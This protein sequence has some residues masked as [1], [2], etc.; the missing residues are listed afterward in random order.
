M[1]PTLRRLRSM[2][3]ASL[4]VLGAG[5]LCT[6][7][8][9]ADSTVAAIV[10]FLAVLLVSGYSRMLEAVIADII[11]AFWLDYYHIPP[12]GSITIGD[13]QGWFALLVFLAVSLI[14]T[15][16]SARLRRQRDQLILQQTE[17]EKLHA[18]SRT[19][20][21]ASGAEDGRRLLINKCMELFGFNEVVLFESA[22]SQF[23]R[24]QIH[25]EIPDEKLQ[26]AAL[27]RSVE[28][29]ADLTIIPVELGNKSFGSLAFRGA[30]LARPMLQA[31][32]N[33][34][35]VGLAQAQA[36]E[37][38]GR[39]EAVRRSEEL[40]SVLI[41]ALAHDLKTP[42]TA[43]EAA[44]DILL[45]PSGASASQRYDLLQV[46]REETLRLKRLVGE[47]IHLS[48][49]DAKKLKLEY[50]TVRVPELIDGAVESLGGRLSTHQISIEVPPDLPAVF[51][52]R[53]LILQSLK[54]LLD[55]AIKYSPP[56]S[57]VTI[58]AGEA[59]GFVSISVRDQGQGLTELE[60]TRVF[61]K[62]YRG[63]Y[64]GSAIQGTGM[65]LAIAREISEAHGGSIGVESEIGKGSR[66]TITLRPAGT[67]SDLQ[68]KRS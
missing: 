36:R 34:I 29:S 66:F 64:D 41:D 37:A 9:H 1:H 17:S 26:R 47:A 7:V 18:L 10:L 14:A 43:I 67:R 13:V 12:V 65:G 56:R 35:A 6:R 30:S 63:R 62:F 58:S 28:E 46:V 40:K 32:G 51:A 39:A 57:V 23:H 20:L 59:N 44:T 45:S 42:L 49:I 33:T 27:H 38:A 5:L 21:L 11:A 68:D 55:N 53:E 54:Q 24:S 48:R 60:Q 22:T 61:D 25:T 3:A 4:A 15:N 50:E 16:L 31:I 52:D 8:L 2:L 19:M